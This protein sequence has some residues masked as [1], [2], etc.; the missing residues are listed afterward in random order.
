[1]SLD[2]P[3]S[4][5]LFK[6]KNTI[7]NTITATATMHPITIT[8]IWPPVKP[9]SIFFQVSHSDLTPKVPIIAAFLQ[10]QNGQIVSE[11]SNPHK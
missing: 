10:Q 8:T 7:V 5:F 4:F 6:A 3:L 1:M 2:S 11:V 9:V